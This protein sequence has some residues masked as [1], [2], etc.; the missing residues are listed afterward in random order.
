MAVYD[1]SKRLWQE[2][3]MIYPRH[4]SNLIDG[5]KEDCKCFIQCSPYPDQDWTSDPESKNYESR[6]LQRDLQSHGSQ[7]RVIMKL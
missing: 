7:K 3:V 5:M 2:A 6:S 1:E 4:Y